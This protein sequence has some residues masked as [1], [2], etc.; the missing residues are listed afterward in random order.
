MEGGL[1]DTSQLAVAWLAACSGNSRQA[2]RTAGQQLA[3]GSL[4][5][6][7]LQGTAHTLHR[8]RLLQAYVPLLQLLSC[9][10]AAVC[11]RAPARAAT[12]CCACQYTRTVFMFSIFHS[13]G[14]IAWLLVQRIMD[15]TTNMMILTMVDHV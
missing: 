13:C 3:G 11:M 10:V 5:G 6:H 7:S 15:S 4:E 9:S 2:C 14:C 8:S 12:Y 1:Q